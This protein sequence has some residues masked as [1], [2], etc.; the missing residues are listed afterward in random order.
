M[1]YQLTHR[2]HAQARRQRTTCP[3][4][5]RC[6]IVGNNW[7]AWVV[8]RWLSGNREDAVDETVALRR[9]NASCSQMKP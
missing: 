9:S 4:V 1:Y 3:V 5:G 8:G 2:P 6:G 7:T